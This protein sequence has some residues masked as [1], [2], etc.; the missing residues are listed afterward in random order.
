[1]LLSTHMFV[2]H[3]SMTINFFICSKIF[4]KEIENPR[5]SLWHFRVFWTEQAVREFPK[6]VV[7]LGPL[8]YELWLHLDLWKIIKQW[9]L[10]I[11]NGPRTWYKESPSLWYTYGKFSV[12]TNA[13]AYPTSEVY[14]YR[15]LIFLFFLCRIDLS[16][17]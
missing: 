12:S 5:G 11:F 14:V 1:M 10:F 2:S 8:R 7:S 4:L 17:R 15:A 3:E 13:H 16:L 9:P 6:T